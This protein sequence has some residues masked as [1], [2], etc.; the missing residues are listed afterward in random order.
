MMR[1]KVLKMPYGLNWAE[2]NRCDGI[3]NG[4][5]LMCLSVLILQK[6]GALRFWIEYSPSE[7]NQ[8]TVLR[9]AKAIKS[10]VN[11]FHS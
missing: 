2:G 1:V 7:F 5:Y 3:F 10:T 6:Q 4:A 11:Q 8:I 9:E